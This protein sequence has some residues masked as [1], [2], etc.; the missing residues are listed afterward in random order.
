MKPPADS[1]ASLPW[2][3]HEALLAEL[4]SIDE[5]LARAEAARKALGQVLG[6]GAAELATLRLRARARHQDRALRYLTAK[7]AEQLSRPAVAALRAAFVSE[8]LAAC[9]AERRVFD[10]TSGLGADGL[11]LA[12]EGLETHLGDRDGYTLACARAN[13]DGAGVPARSVVRCDARALP[14]RPSLVRDSALVLDPDRRP[15][16]ERE[17]DPAFWSPTL[18]QCLDLAQSA[19]VACIK[20]APAIEPDSL[21]LA[22]HRHEATWVSCDGELVEVTLWSGAGARLG[23]AR[24]AIVLRNQRGRAEASER[25]T[26]LGRPLEGVA[27]WTYAA[28]PIEIDAWS[29]DAARGVRWLVEPDPAL[30]RAGH[31]GALAQDTGL[32]P[33]APRCAYLGGDHPGPTGLTRSWPVLVSTPLDRKHLRRALGEL[34]IGSL[35]VKKRGHPDSA[36][37]LARRFRGPGRAPGIVAVARLAV[38]HAAFVLG[39]EARGEAPHQP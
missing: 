6:P 31:I 8:A 28:E 3:S 10:P 2:P 26:P 30:I 38:G 18:A 27:C 19:Q 11:A 14:W 34:D 5:P 20:L 12:R 16:G 36:D 24:R 21:P 9:G 22:A 25:D 17:S 32:R 4:E 13:L 15:T 39:P 37:V 33:L 29:P 1:R 23:H 35:T 7:G